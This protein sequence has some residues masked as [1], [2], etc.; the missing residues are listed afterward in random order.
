MAEP[1]KP[2]DALLRG[3]RTDKRQ[4]QY[5]NYMI[6]YTIILIANA[7]IGITFSERNVYHRIS[8]E[9]SSFAYV[10]NP[11]V[12]Q[13]VNRTLYSIPI[14]P[15]YVIPVTC[16]MLIYLALCM[17]IIYS[18]LEVKREEEV[19]DE[20]K[21]DAVQQQ[22]GVPLN[23]NEYH[24]LSHLIVKLITDVVL[25]IVT[26]NF[27]VDKDIERNLICSVSVLLQWLCYC[28]VD[29]LY[30]Q[31]FALFPVQPNELTT[32]CLIHYILYLS[33]FM[34]WTLAFVMSIY[35]ITMGMNS[36]PVMSPLITRLYA[37]FLV[38]QIWD[39]LCGMSSM[40]S[41]TNL[42]S[43]MTGRGLR[44]KQSQNV[45][46]VTYHFMTMILFWVFMITLDELYHHDPSKP[47]FTGD[48]S[49]L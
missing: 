42:R 35:T 36:F 37:V 29:G 46:Y 30:V 12:V 43:C 15:L 34:I 32:F 19:K 11:I 44:N 49:I 24:N 7:S 14:L 25:W 21:P 31:L 8:F 16:N 23:P 40:W 41:M 10:P 20:P 33:I 38:K 2:T 5:M 48:R 22:P 47:L 4:R 26:F 13:S 1:E 45:Y 6:V 28:I 3:T 18:Y 17:Q 39:Y 27:L 9:T